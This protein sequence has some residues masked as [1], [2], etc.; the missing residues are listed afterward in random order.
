M[1][2]TIVLARSLLSPMQ[3]CGWRFS[4]VGERVKDGCFI[5]FSTLAL[6]KMMFCD[7]HLSVYEP[8]IPPPLFATPG[9]SINFK[10]LCKNSKSFYI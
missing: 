3:V 5:P 6:F 2:A 7:G 8:K 4:A 9:V 1:P 10:Q